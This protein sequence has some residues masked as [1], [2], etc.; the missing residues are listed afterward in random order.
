MLEC[1]WERT[2]I[3]IGSKK[4]LDLTVTFNSDKESKQEPIPRIREMFI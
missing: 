3:Q 1:V 4:N 2:E